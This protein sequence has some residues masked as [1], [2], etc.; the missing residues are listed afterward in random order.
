[1]RA[2]S[3][4]RGLWTAA[5]LC[6]GAA[7]VVARR[8]MLGETMLNPAVWERSARAHIQLP[9]DSL[10]AAAALVVQSDPFRVSHQP[11][12]Q[13]FG[14]ASDALMPAPPRAARPPLLLQGVV[15]HPGRWEAVVAGIPGREGGIVVRVGDTLAGLRIRRIDHDTVIVVAAD[16][17]WR[18]TVKG[19]W[20]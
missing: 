14:A 20:P 4:E 2:V 18:L 13:N 12:T 6:L 7:A 9:D 10:A 19:A 3:T 5:L 17:I 11:A 16:T 1:M 15:G 8:P